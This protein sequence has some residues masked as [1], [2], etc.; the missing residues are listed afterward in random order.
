MGF[1]WWRRFV[2]DPRHRDCYR[3]SAD[4]HDY[5]S[6]IA[7]I[8]S[9]NANGAQ[10][11]EAHVVSRIAPARCLRYAHVNEFIPNFIHKISDHK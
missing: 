7:H 9:I 5:Q 2:R 4:D 10:Q 11:T 3:D 8:S 1:G 6:G